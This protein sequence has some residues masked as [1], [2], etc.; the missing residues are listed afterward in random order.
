MPPKTRKKIIAIVGPTASG[1]T[2]A[3]YYLA[4]K[5]HGYIISADSRQLYQGMDI[6]TNKDKPSP[7]PQYLIDIIKPDQNFTVAQYQQK[8][9]A[10]IDDTPGLPFLTGGTGLYI[11][12]IINNLNIPKIPPDYEL[13]E[14]LEQEIKD[15]G[16][17]EVYKKLLKLDAKIKGQLDPQNPRR[18]IRALEVC[19][20]SDQP[21][22]S[23][24][25]PRA[26]KYDSLQLGMTIPRAE[27]YQRINNRV[28]D[29]F[30]IGLVEE[31]KSLLKAGYNSTLPSMSGIG[32]KE[33]AEYLNNKISLEKTKELIKQR[34]RNYARKQ[35]TWFKKDKTIRW[36]DNTKEGEVIIA[37]FLVK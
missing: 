9:F 16:L 35:L 25:I 23:Q 10:L 14:K 36:I 19:L 33:T 27:L 29:M 4:K 1:K 8:V 17:K 20:K 34:T 32:Y 22:S 30:K 28:E 15:K 5:Y 12:A 26:P 2:T 13:R 37:K 7:L 3:A 6:A 31:V 21:F 18:V 24:L 11:S